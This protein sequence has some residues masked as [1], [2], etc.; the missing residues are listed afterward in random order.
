MRSNLCAPNFSRTREEDLSGGGFGFER[1]I[2]LSS[3]DTLGNFQAP[4]Y[5][6]NYLDN[7]DRI[8]GNRE[9]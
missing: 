3:N 6:S 9:S 7:R 4:V 1:L 5:P 8:L 2:I